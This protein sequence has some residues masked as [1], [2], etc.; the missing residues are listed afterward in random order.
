MWIIRIGCR[1]AARAATQ[2]RNVPHFI[3]PAAGRHA[4]QGSA[5]TPVFTCDAMQRL[6]TADR[7][8]FQANVAERSGQHAMWRTGLL[9]G[10]GTVC[11]SREE[12]APAGGSRAMSQLKLEP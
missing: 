8:L 1:F 7:R 5:D 10:L 11:T 4:Q 6:L 12:N 3:P 2:A 9:L